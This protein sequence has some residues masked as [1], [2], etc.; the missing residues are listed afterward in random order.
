MFSF[1]IISIQLGDDNDVVGGT[2]TFYVDFWKDIP[3]GERGLKFNAVPR[4]TD[5]AMKTKIEICLESLTGCFL[6][7]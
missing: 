5:S 1:V 7:S 3:L 4:R 2:L 6:F